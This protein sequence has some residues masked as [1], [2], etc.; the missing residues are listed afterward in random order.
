MTIK[1]K[2]YSHEKS[3]ADDNE[4]CIIATSKKNLDKYISAKTE[5]E[6]NSMFLSGSVFHVE[7]G[8]KV[9]IV[10]NNGGAV[11]VKI[12]TGDSNGKTVWTFTEAVKKR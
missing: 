1:Q 7:D 12:L 10:E 9:K 4:N 6:L 3:S 2:F 11:K 8:V 5:S